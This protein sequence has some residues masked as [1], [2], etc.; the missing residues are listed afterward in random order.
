MCHCSW[1]Q[2]RTGTAFAVEPVFEEHQVEIRGGLLS[3]YR[4]VSDESGRW[5]DL[6]FCP[7]C[8]TSI[9]FTLEWRPGVRAI[10]AGTFDDPSW[11]RADRY[12]FRY[13]YMSSAQDW[14][15]VPAGAE[16]HEK[17]FAT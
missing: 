11:I 1:C 10:D 4:H 12:P 2:K 5:L 13:I 3:H 15:V 7:T 9:G 8:G 16:Q 6:D 17:H 14:S